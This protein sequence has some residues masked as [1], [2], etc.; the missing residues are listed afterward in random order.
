MR[1]TGRR[2][3]KRVAWVALARWAAGIIVV[4][5]GLTKFSGH[6]AGLA[7]FRHY[8]LPAPDAFVYLVGVIELGGGLLLLVGL[9][10]R[11]AAVA[12]A[13]GMAGAIVV[14]GLARGELIS[15]TLAPVLLAV[16]PGLTG[17]GAGSWSLDCRTAGILPGWTQQRS[18]SRP[19]RS[20]Q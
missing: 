7:S 19:A 6:A 11:L 12:L 2:P 8:P 4:V 3:V 16:M 10:T 9:I 5:F 13:A 14:S 18:P 15:L 17:L 20:H 1:R